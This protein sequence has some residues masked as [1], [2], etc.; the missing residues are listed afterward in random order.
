MG[1]FKLL[2][3]GLGHPAVGAGDQPE[4]PLHVVRHLVERR[5]PSHP[6]FSSGSTRGA[7]ATLLTSPKSH[8]NVHGGR[9]GWFDSLG[10]RE[11]SPL[12]C[13][14]DDVVVVHR[15]HQADGQPH[16]LSQAPSW[17]QDRRRTV[18]LETKAN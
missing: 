10:Q 1:P 5:V 8:L 3:E 9:Q 16:L 15:R 12:D 4:D 2:H 14:V 18:F 11:V 6:D 7:W 13:P 17:S